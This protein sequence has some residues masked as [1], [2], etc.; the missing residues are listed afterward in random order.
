MALVELTANVAGSVREETLE[1]T[2]YLVAPVS[3]IVPGVLPGSNG[4]LLYTLNEIEK[5][6]LA[7]NY[8]PIVVHHPKRDG[9]PVSAR[10]PEII[11]NRK[12]GI[13]LRTS[14]TDKLSAEGWFDIAKTKKVDKTVLNALQEGRPFELSTGLYVDQ[15]SVPEGSMHINTKGQ[16]V[17]YSAIATNYRP[18]HL[19]V[20][21]DAKGACS[22]KD[23]CGV[24]V[25]EDE[26]SP[27]N[28][29]DT[30]IQ[31]LAKK[32]G[33]DL[34]PIDNDQSH[35]A[36]YNNLAEQLASRFTQT[37]PSVWIDE[38]FDTYIVYRQG[39][40]LYRLAYS[41]SGDTVTLSTTPPVEVH[42]EVSFNPVSNTET[43]TE[44]SMSLTANERSKVITGIIANCDCWNDNDRETLNAL[45]DAKLQSLVTK[46]PAEPSQDQT[47][48]NAL[49]EGFQ[50][51]ETQVVFNEATGKFEE[52]KE[53]APVANADETEA[54][55]EVTEAEWLANAPSG[56]RSAVQNAMLV[57]SN[58]KQAIV[59]KLTA[60]VADDKKAAVA[61]RLLLKDLS[62]LQ[63][64][65]SLIP[66]APTANSFSNNY[67]GAGS[68]D[69]VLNRISNGSAQTQNKLDQ[70][71][72]LMPPSTIPGMNG[73]N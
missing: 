15:V 32:I 31:R 47:V 3:M 71:D 25:N 5:N 36:R 51:G 4:P 42:R 65:E 6:F 14:V 67:F 41:K 54:P 22:M 45:D 37:D 40:K 60:N 10:D 23:G 44:E 33:V 16:H 72:I 48:L 12:I 35:S 8:M 2:K 38:V 39:D 64:L 49:K 68:P 9:I 30:L 59:D 62:E 34:G 29:S 7:W 1:G 21:T 55:A 11:E 73:R 63:D 58:A 26:E 19:A 13:V 52:K 24:L 28:T 17:P 61:E 27:S 56:I 43:P 66:A 18:D 46:T 50:I 53:P 70:D 57:E 69:Q 20:F